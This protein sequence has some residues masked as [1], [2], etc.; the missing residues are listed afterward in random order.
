M[1]II[2]LVKQ[3]PTRDGVLR[4]S[5]NGAGLDEAG[6]TYEMNGPDAYA[7]EAGLQLREKWGGEVVVLSAGP[8]RVTQTI[9]E[10]LA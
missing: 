2:V 9:R 4:I 10:A 7:L 3:V 8:E 5:A 1:K 6:V